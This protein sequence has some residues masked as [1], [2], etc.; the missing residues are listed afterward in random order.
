MEFVWA[1]V[2]SIIPVLSEGNLVAIESTCPPGT[3]VKVERKI[4]AARPEL[5]GQVDVA[6]CPE[7]ILPGNAVE[8]LR[9][10]DRTIGGTTEQASRHAA[11]LYKSFCDGELLITDATSAEMVKL[12][13]NAY[14]DV[15]IAFA[16]ELSLI[17]DTLD[18]DPW[19]VIELANRHPRV[20]ILK[21]GPG[22]GG[23]CIAVDP[24]FLIESAP[25]QA[26]ITRTAREVNDR[27][28][29]WVIAKA[30]SIID[31]LD[32]RK[33]AILGLSFKADIDDLRQSPALQIASD[34]ASRNP[35]TN[36]IAVEP[37][38]RDTP[39]QFNTPNISWTPALPSDE[40]L[41]LVVWL[42]DH[43]EF[44]NAESSI[45]RTVPILDACGNR[46]RLSR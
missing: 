21:P 29:D 28:P 11:D 25:Q 17:A 31:R 16:N 34:L 1:A 35:E 12:A 33:V 23:H 22:V 10:N 45:Y 43:Q 24:W 20:N 8:E 2:E 30:E 14:R 6:Y 46:S 18:V 13:E 32:P 3:T 37:N 38:I 36:F 26:E 7:R 4:V 44:R 41:Q 40:E 27:K 42:V 39:T 19:Q 15:N 5:E 9:I